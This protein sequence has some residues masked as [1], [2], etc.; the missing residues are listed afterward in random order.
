MILKHEVVYSLKRVVGE[1]VPNGDDL[2]NNRQA[3]HEKEAAHPMPDLVCSNALSQLSAYSLSVN[4][5]TIKPRF[6]ATSAPNSSIGGFN[7]KDG[8]VE[9]KFKRISGKE[10]QTGGL[11]WRAKIP[12]TTLQ[13][14]MPSKTTSPFTTRSMAGELKRS[15]RI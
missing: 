7:L 13:V 3:A 9:V 10:D 2:Y 14:L 6:L 11:I 1:Q 8:F 5:S 4:T 12:T 15:A